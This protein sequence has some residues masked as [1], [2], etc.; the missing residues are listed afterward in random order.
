MAQSTTPDDLA[1]S[2]SQSKM[3]LDRL[4]DVIDGWTR[5]GQQYPDFE[6]MAADRAEFV[7]PPWDTA[8]FRVTSTLAFTTGV[9]KALSFDVTD[10]NTGIIDYST[11]STGLFRFTRPS[12]FRTFLVFGH[13]A[14]RYEASSGPHGLR[15]T[16]YPSTQDVI[17]SQ[18][19]GDQVAQSYSY[20]YRV[21][22]GTTAFD[23]EVFAVTLPYLAE[24]SLGLWE[25]TRQ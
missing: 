7:Y 20:V 2:L 6:F 10:W 1:E 3:N 8:G 21:P 24:A 4:S 16:S 17:M 25:L 22:A 11:A 12:D 23:I 13:I 14:W 5:G 15:I 19:H 9:W 18:L